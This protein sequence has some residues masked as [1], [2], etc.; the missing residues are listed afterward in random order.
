MIF[1]R[2]ILIPQFVEFINE[3]VYSMSVVCYQQGYPIW[4]TVHYCIVPRRNEQMFVDQRL[5]K[6]YKHTPE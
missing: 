4:Y 6:G 1:F 5:S 3:I 2:Q